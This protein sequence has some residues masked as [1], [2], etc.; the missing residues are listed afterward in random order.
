LRFFPTCSYG[1]TSLL[2]PLLIFRLSGS[3]T[4]AAIYATTNLLVATGAQILVG[5][6]VDRQGP[7]KPARW[8]SALIVG[9]AACTAFATPSLPV[10]FVCG[11]V[12]TSAAWSLSTTMTSLVREVTATAD[13]GRALGLVHLLWATGML[14]GTVVAGAL[15]SVNPSLPFALFGAL[16]VFSVLA[17]R[18]LTSGPSR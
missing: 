17:A 15:V 1:A 18:A 11:I 2:L 4:V 8:L 12:A 6:A 3:V 13:R 7:F 10:L 16:N 9:S 14:V 5:R